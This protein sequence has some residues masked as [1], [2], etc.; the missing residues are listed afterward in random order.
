M[1]R[2]SPP[3]ALVGLFALLLASCQSPDNPTDEPEAVSWQRAVEI[4]NAGQVESAFQTHQLSVELHLKDGSRVQTTEP[5]IDEIMRVIA[6]CGRPCD[7][8]VF[9][10]E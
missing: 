4:V 3:A 10:T 9:A 1:G 5:T 7:Q 6:S 8:I 2:S